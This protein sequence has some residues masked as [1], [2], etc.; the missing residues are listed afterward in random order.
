VFAQ[1]PNLTEQPSA[2]H[3]QIVVARRTITSALDLATLH[4][5]GSILPRPPFYKG[6]R[7][8]LFRL[9]AGDVSFDVNTISAPSSPPT[10]AER[11]VPAFLCRDV[12][13][14]S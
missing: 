14:P 7:L 13:T 3:I 12:R 6:L 9:T 2:I 4:A 11:Q 10:A 8:F 5:A 1:V